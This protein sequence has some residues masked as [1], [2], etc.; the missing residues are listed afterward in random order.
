MGIHVDNGEFNNVLLHNSFF[1][2]MFKSVRNRDCRF[3]ADDLAVVR[4]PPMF[5]IVFDVTPIE[6]KICKQKSLKLS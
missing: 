5:S 1:N 6:N 3:S 2:E 4:M